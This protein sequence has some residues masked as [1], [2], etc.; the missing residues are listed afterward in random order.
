M[1]N[2]LVALSIFCLAVCFVI[3]SWLIANG[4]KNEVKITN[5]QTQQQLLTQ[6]ELADYLGLSVEEIQKLGPVFAGEGVTT[7]EIPYIKIRNKFYYSKIA[8]DKWLQRQ[9][10]LTVQ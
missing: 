7:S 1:K 5:Q 3:G 9:D 2:N 10:S 8:I 6:P 4:L